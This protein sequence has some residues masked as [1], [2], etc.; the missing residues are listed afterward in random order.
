MSSLTSI[1]FLLR[2]RIEP[3]ITSRFEIKVTDTRVCHIRSMHSNFLTMLIYFI[4]HSFSLS[5]RAPP[6]VRRRRER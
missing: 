4:T 3:I 2:R 5:S 6:A 1:E